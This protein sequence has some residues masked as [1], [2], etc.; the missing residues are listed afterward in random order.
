MTRMTRSALTCWLLAVVTVASLPSAAQLAGKPLLVFED[1]IRGTE[2]QDIRWPV[3]VASGG[4]DELAVADAHTPR[5]LL[6][7]RTG[8]A[9]KLAGAAGLPAAPAGLAWDGGRYVLSLRGEGRLLAVEGD[10]LV[11]RNVPLPRGTVPGPIDG[12]LSGGLVVYDLAGGRVLRLEPDGEL[13]EAL[14]VDGRVTALAAA[15]GDG[16][17]TAVGEAGTVRRH[18]ADGSVEESW[19]VP[20]ET[21]A[22]AWPAGLAA[23]PG[24]DL[25]VVDRHNDRVLVFRVGGTMAGFGSRRGW[26]PGLIRYPSDVTLVGDGEVAVADQGNGR[27]QVYQRLRKGSGQ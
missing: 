4:P 23:E 15:P 10:N 6:F 14:P 7:R 19:T 20:T 3:A 18:G 11:L 26:E 5:L 8:G 17:F 24:G 2:E 9:W 1:E 25:L 21:P 12:R 13:E 22:P 16:F 27:V